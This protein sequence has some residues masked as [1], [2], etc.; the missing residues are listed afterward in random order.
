VSDRAVPT[1]RAA[2]GRR[3][4]AGRAAWVMTSQA[5]SSLSNFVLTV[6]VARS[7]DQE[8]FGWFALAFSA[9]ALTVSFARAAV[10]QPL[11]VR[12]GADAARRQVE[13]AAA[14]GAACVVGVA[15]GVAAA[16]AGVIVQL[17]G[18]AGGALLVMGAA[19]PVVI[20]QDLW[21]Y[22]FITAAQPR[23]AAANDLVWL[24]VQTVL[25]GALF[26]GTSPSAPPLVAAWGIAALVASAYGVRQSR[27]FPSLA[28]GIGYLRRHRDLGGVLVLETVVHLGSAYLVMFALAPVIG[29][30]GLGA[31]RGAQALFGPYTLIV[32]GLLA[33]G[34]AEAGRLRAEGG[35]RWVTWLRL[36]SSGLVVAALAF[37]TVLALLP[38]PVGEA[39]LGDTWQSARPLIAPF[40]VGA[41]GLGAAFGGLVGLRVVEAKRDILRITGLANGAAAIASVGAG[42]VGGLLPAAWAS[43]LA[44]WIYAAGAWRVV[45]GAR[46]APEESPTRGGDDGTV[47][48]AGDCRDP[49]H[50]AAG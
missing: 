36:A 5:L 38:D 30:A 18:G 26:A 47:D 28:G 45:A 16:A 14:A 43:A 33:A 20:L 23:R 3:P 19:L 44:P 7:V 35:R 2:S 41:V 9:Y 49:D 25:F 17:T 15:G 32:A 27:M 40:T 13:S 37:G 10:G 21:R 42:L 12:F 29:A 8:A 31:L 22:V 46:S 6:V 50:A 11:A 1:A 24:G 34:P 48:A 39:V 4:L